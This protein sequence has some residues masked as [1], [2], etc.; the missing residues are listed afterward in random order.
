MR[1]EAYN[2]VQQIYQPNKVNKARQ[3]GGASQAKEQLQFSSMGR[4]IGVAQTAIAQ[5]PDVREDLTASIKA[6]MQNG[7]YHVD[8]GTFAEKLLRKY[9]EMR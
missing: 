1:I 7:T 4:D 3:A 2:Q 8:A 5:T 6:R 9:E